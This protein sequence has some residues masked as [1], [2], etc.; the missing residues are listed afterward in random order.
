[1]SLVLN[2]FSSAKV[3]NSLKKD[4]LSAK[5]VFENN[6]TDSASFESIYLI[7][8]SFFK[9][10]FFKILPNLI[11]SLLLSPII[12]L[13]GYKLSY[14]AFPSLKNSG[15]NIIFFF[16]YFFLNSLVYPIGIV[17]LIIIVASLFTSI[18]FLIV[19]STLCVSNTF[20]DI[21]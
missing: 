6:F 14:K 16:L 4:I 19:S 13:E 7:T 12:I 21:L 17:D 11:A 3:S 1:M 10:L 15:E 20:V 9:E 18:I 8:T 2:P 5:Y